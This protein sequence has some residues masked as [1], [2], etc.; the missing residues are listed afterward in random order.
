MFGAGLLTGC[1]TGPRRPGPL[2]SIA[3]RSHPIPSFI[4]GS[5][6]T[7][8]GALEF[9]S[10]LELEC[11]DPD[12]G[13]LSA[14]GLQP[15]GRRFLALSDQASWISGEIL[16]ENG[17][18]IGIGNAELAPIRG[19]KGVPLATQ[20]R[21]D[22][23]CIARDG[24][25][26]YVGIE[27]KNRIYRFDLAQ[28]GLDAQGEEIALPPDARKLHPLFGFESLG[29]M[30]AQS[31]RA[32]TLIAIAEED[33]DRAGRIPGYFLPQDGP[34]GRFHIR[35][36]GRFRLTDIAFLPGGDLL[37]LERSQS[38]WSSLEIRLRR[39]ALAELAEGAEI[40]GRII[41]G[42]DS[43]AQVDNMEGLSVH[44][45]EAGETIVTMV[46][47]NNF[48]VLQRTML[49]QWRLADDPA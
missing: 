14:L 38:I 23:E 34:A 22:T 12:F 41:F 48:S 31:D 24:D 11:D 47:D 8:F 9:L 49:L 46:S 3:I 5:A 36:D 6:Q 20:K 2:H 10:G 13:G 33:P 30:P 44:R 15:D 35:K 4:S 43:T 18:M 28:G 40:E 1:S 7:R 37:V 42:C 29:I 27:E 39:I 16:M 32:G 19:P 26:A 25:V 17:R 45:N 21:W